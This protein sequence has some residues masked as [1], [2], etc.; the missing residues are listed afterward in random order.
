[1]SITYSECVFVALVI[2][3]A[4]RMRHV[5][6]PSVA[7][8]VLQYFPTLSHKRHDFREKSLNTRCVFWFSIQILSETFLIRR[9]T[10]RDMIKNVYRSSCK[11]PVIVVRFEW[12]L[13]LLDIFSKNTQI[14][15]LM[16]ICPVGNG[17]TDK[18]DEANIPFS[19]F[20]DRT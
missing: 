11:V 9:R 17:R 20:C 10:E 4:M 16:K 15:K 1:M 3:R 18:Y 6:L 5:I 19:Q 7:C 2:G 12:N 14:S 13:N 8:P